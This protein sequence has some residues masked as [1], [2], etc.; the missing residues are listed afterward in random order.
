METATL[1]SAIKS[2]KDWELFDSDRGTDL[3]AFVRSYYIPDFERW[4]EH[5]HYKKAFA[6][7]M[8]D[9]KSGERRKE[10]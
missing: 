9:L 7:L 5:E 2:I 8:R 1:G 10:E 6:R 4:K 3:A